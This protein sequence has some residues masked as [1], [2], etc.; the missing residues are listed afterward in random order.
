M[1]RMEIDSVWTKR[2]DESHE[3]EPQ[4]RHWSSN[5]ARAQIALFIMS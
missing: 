3:T 1:K 5:M 4:G 2:K